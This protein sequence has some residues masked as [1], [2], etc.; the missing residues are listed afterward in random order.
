METTIVYGGNIG[1]VENKMETTGMIGVVASSSPREKGPHAPYIYPDQL[2]T[3]NLLPPYTP[4]P[5]PEIP[6]SATAPTW[7]PCS[8]HSLPLTL[9][10]KTPNA[11]A[12]ALA[13]SAEEGQRSF[14]GTLQDLSDCSHSWSFD[15]CVFHTGRRR[16]PRHTPYAAC[17]ETGDGRR[18]RE[19]TL[20]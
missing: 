18:E 9:T 15:P 4:N 17:R 20:P 14:L 2:R 10:L 11:C 5:Q 19:K 3:G 16:W 12:L 13:V 6:G 7:Q 1:I 8:N